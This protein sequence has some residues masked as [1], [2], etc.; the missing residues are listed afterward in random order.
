[1]RTTL[2]HP[3]GLLFLW[4]AAGVAAASLPAVGSELLVD[5]PVADGAVLQR[6][7]EVP[8][9]GS[10]EPGA[11]VEVT[12]NGRAHSTRAD[13][14]GRWQVKLPPML[15]GGPF[16]LTVA[17]AGEQLRVSDLLVGDVWLCSGQSNMEWVVADSLHAEDEIAAASDP[18]IRHFKVPRSWAARPESF[19]AGGSWEPADPEHVGS[20]T[21]VGTFFARA[22]REHVKIPIGLIH[23]SWGGS[24]IEPWMSAG[25]IGLDAADVGKILDDEKVFEAEVLAA[26]RARVGELPD[27]DHGL[28]DGR[29][30]WAAPDLDD[31]K[32]DQV[33]VPSAWEE[34]GYQDMDGIAWYRTSFEL[35]AK[36]AASRVQLGLAFI[37]DSDH[38]CWVNGHEVGRT[39]L[40][41]NRLRVYQLAPA[42]LKPGRNTVAV[43]V[44][45]TGGGGGIWGDPQ[46]LCVDTGS[47]RVPLAGTWRFRV[48]VATVN[49]DFHKNQLPTMLFNKMIYPLY[50]YPIA[51]VLWYQGESNA[52]GADASAYRTLFPAMIS[53][54]RRGWQ[55]ED[56]P[57]L[58]VQLANYLPEGQ[59]P[60]VSS[61][62]VLRESQATA[63]SLANT[64]QVVAID[65]G[66]PHD[67]H[68][69]DKQ[70]VGRRL[71]L[72]ARKL[73]YGE[74]L[75]YS[76]PVYRSHEIEDGRITV[77]FDHTGS[78]LVL[79]GDTESGA[80]CFAVAGSDRRFLPTQVRVEEDQ[81]VVWN[82]EISE[83]VALRYAW[84]DN[85]LGV[86]LYN[87]EGLPASP[88]R[89]DT[90]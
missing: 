64:A 13:D 27:H 81:V 28:V 26:I 77:R 82:D 5:L 72:A 40:A 33:P 88:F 73:L 42:V 59:E 39:E 87:H 2:K 56:L 38:Q 80:S 66:E 48:G 60:A 10:A 74:D 21:A 11:E 32:W 76:G 50:A 24:R 16:E 63:L 85:P 8:I 79:R 47:R 7:V 51:G 37:D 14:S 22:L 62:A 86:Q 29:A 68:P 84:A 75:V 57:F 20:F 54:W 17:A 78:G 58:F 83:P 31:S 89:T 67:V 1:M 30:L 43:R 15:A 70:E 35:S 3:R 25:A 9:Q 71:S 12:C 49:L 41:W 4:L 53:D 65:I 36:E 34:A 23:S 61:W 45:D 44:E 18:M 55:R 6:G 90:W 69:G 52:D 46:L 19:L